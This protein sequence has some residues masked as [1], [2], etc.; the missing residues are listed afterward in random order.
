MNKHVQFQEFQQSRECHLDTRNKN[1][2][3]P[4]Y[5]HTSTS[6]PILIRS[7]L[8]QE[9]ENNQVNVIHLNIWIL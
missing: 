1:E 6:T 9:G 5:P 3:I 2:V 7:I 8:L 4:I